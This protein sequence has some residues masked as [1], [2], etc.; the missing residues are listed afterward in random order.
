[1][2]KRQAFLI[3]LPNL[4]WQYQHGFPTWVDLNNVRKTG[5]NTVLPP[6]RFL[7]QQV[8]MLN[9]A[10]AIVWIAGL[11]F[12]LFHRE[13]KRYRSLGVTYLAFLAVMMALHL[14]LIH[15]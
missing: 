7:L 3:C 2:Y 12:L 1:M 13:G 8:L 4:I 11:G 14:S 6:L 10:G 9:P 5:K 15:I